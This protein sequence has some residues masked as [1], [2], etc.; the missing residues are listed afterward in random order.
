VPH[1]LKKCRRVIA[2]KISELNLILFLATHHSPLA[3]RI[4][5][6]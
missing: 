4:T 5:A 3:T 1:S 6:S 2:A